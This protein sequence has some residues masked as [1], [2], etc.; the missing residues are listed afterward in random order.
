MNGVMSFSH[1]DP[2]ADSV[3]KSHL[4]DGNGTTCAICPA[5]TNVRFG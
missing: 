2:D 3:K 4:S 5:Q 1:D